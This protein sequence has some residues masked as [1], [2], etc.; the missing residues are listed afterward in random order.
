MSR[1]SARCSSW[2]D[3][4]LGVALFAAPGY[5][6]SQ[7]LL[8]SHMAA[9][10][11]SVATGLSLCVPVLGGLLYG[12]RG[13]PLHRNAWFGLL[14]GVTLACSA[15]LLLRRRGGTQ[16]SLG[17]KRQNWNLPLR[18]ATAFGAAALIAVSAVG[19]ARVGAAVQHYPG[20]TQL[21]LVRPNKNAPM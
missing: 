18:H 16:M 10:N 9:W 20:Y 7:L 4:V 1:L 6:L 21:S 3:S 2:A 12:S 11:G 14:T 5:L 8:G 19:L 13:L 17:P 15:V